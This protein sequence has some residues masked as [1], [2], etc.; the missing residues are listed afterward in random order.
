VPGEELTIIN[1]YRRTSVREVHLH[2]VFDGAATQSGVVRWDLFHL[3]GRKLLGGRKRVVLRP[4][5]SGR[6]KTLDLGRLMEKHG[7]D[8]LHLRI[9]LDVGGRCVSEDTVFL[10]PPRFLGLRKGRTR[11]RLKLESPKT[12][13]ATFTSTVFQH[14][15]AFDL[16]GI[17]HFASDNYFELFPG[18]PKKVSLEFGQAQSLESLRRVL[19]HRSL[20]DTY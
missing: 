3:D 19:D 17:S 10:T 6:Q 14:R 11:V 1:N 7:R 16:P 20:V 8:N 18:E 5:E 4:G 13:T 15:F 9:A 2:T 12:A